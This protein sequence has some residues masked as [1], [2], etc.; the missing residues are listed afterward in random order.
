MVATA[1]MV[2]AIAASAAA[3]YQGSKRQSKVLKQQANIAIKKGE[4]EKVQNKQ[5]TERV[6]RQIEAS[7][8]KA[9]GL[10]GS[11]LENLNK[12]MANAELDQQMIGFNASL[13]SENYKFQ[14]S[15][16]RARGTMA[17]I[18]GVGKAAGAIGGMGNE[19]PDADGGDE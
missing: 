13:Q 17:L 19:D 10:S 3:S 1:I 4:I 9:G 16:A 14:A 8:G 18:E 2:G 15:E 12:S 7:A 6:R 5:R 11:A